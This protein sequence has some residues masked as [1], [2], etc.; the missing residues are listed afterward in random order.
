[1]LHFNEI[2]FKS[3]FHHYD[4]P[5]SGP[6]TTS[7]PIGKQISDIKSSENTPI[8]NFKPIKGPEFYCD[9]S[10]LENHDQNYFWRICHL[11]KDGPEEASLMGFFEISKPGN[12]SNARWLTTASSILYV[13]I[14]TEN[15]SH[16]L[17][18]LA[19]FI[20]NCYAPVFFKIKQER[21]VQNGAKHF[22]QALFLA[23][24]CLDKDEWK[25][26]KKAFVRNCFMA[27]SEYILL[28]GLF[29]DDLWVREKSGQLIIK[30][31]KSKRKGV[32][33]YE[34]PKK[35]L[36]LD[37][38]KSYF[39]LLDFDK[40]PRKFFTPPPILQD[41]SDD[42]IMKAAKGETVLVIPEIPCHSQNCERA[43]AAT[44]FAS[45]KAIGHKKR[46]EFLLNLS[47][48]RQLIKTHATKEDYTNLL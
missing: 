44:T 10:L 22:F 33:K 48:N 3:L 41:F 23:R 6:K 28:A 19:N 4:G 2:I 40:L 45:K 31:R 14:R 35:H 16:E 25:E 21:L 36:R 24:E 5:T 39:D 32:R 18:R 42:E 34:L 27:T 26:V 15:P 13:Y 46:H 17:Y 11:V 8:V 37:T 38:A 43:V 7:G 30:A 12:I 1:M 47:K 20:I 29:D 9:K